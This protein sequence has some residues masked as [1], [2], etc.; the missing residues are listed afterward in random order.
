MRDVMAAL[1]MLP[2]LELKIGL[3]EAVVAMREPTLPLLVRK[4]GELHFGKKTFNYMG[5]RGDLLRTCPR[6]RVPHA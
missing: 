1:Q 6:A 5:L 2:G 3:V 4:V